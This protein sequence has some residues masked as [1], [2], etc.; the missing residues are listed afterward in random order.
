MS[1]PKR[2]AKLKSLLITAGLLASCYLTVPLHAGETITCQSP[3]GK[4]A[5]RHTYAD[6]NPCVG[7]TAIIE[8]A[9]HQTVLPLTSN[10]VLGELKLVW[11]DDS[12]RVAYFEDDENAARRSMRVFFRNGLAFNEIQL[13][14]LP[15]PKL[16]E[17]ATGSDANTG[18]RVEPIKWIEPTDLFLEKEL[19][20]PKWG[21]AAL[22]ITLG[23]DADNRPLVRKV[24]QEK[25]SVVDYFVLLPADYFEGPPAIW[26]RRMQMDARWHL[27]DTEPGAAVIDEKNGCDGDGAQ[28]GFEVALF[29]HRDARPLLA[30]CSDELEGDDSVSLRFFEL[31]ADKKMHEIKRSIFPVA[32]SKDNRWKFELPREGR[33]VVVRARESGRVLHKFTWDGEKFQEE[34]HK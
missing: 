31:G 14:D 21:R 20:N 1:M 23:F 28:P 25:M 4:F 2:D 32:D 5:L 9:T 30:F 27:C 11:S 33:T 15:S 12:Q 7:D 22:K 26:L 10:R 13:P 3:D 8:T 18:T 6:M 16:P 19:I 29:R 24:E 34:K 17:N